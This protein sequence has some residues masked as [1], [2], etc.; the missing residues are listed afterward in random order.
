MIPR[1]AN[2]DKNDLTFL[3]ECTLLDNADHRAQGDLN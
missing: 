2:V 1:R 3:C